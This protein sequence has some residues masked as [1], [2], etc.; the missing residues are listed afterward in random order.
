LGR[1]AKGLWSIA[2]I[3]K[4]ASRDLR[5]SD[6]TDR[7]DIWSD[8]RDIWSD[9]RQWSSLDPQ[10]LKDALAD[11]NDALA[12]P[13]S[14]LNQDLRKNAGVDNEVPAEETD[15]QPWFPPDE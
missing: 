3:R 4:L 8:R 5:V 6:R 13:N 7:R 12:D 1:S 14:Q 2:R 11:I 15:P 9:R 10:V